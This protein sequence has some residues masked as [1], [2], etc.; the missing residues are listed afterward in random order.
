LIDIKFNPQFY[1]FAIN[2]KISDSIKEAINYSTLY[3]I[4]KM[5][6]KVL[7]SESGLD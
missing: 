2:E 1:A 3:N 4:E 7:L 5:D 6:W